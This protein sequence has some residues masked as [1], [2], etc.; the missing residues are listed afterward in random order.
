M[1]GSF[2]RSAIA[3]SLIRMRAAASPPQTVGQELLPEISILLTAEVLLVLSRARDITIIAKKKSQRTD[4]ERD[5]IDLG[6]ARAILL[7]IVIFVPFS[8]ALVLWVVAPFIQPAWI[9]REA[10]DHVF[11]G[12][13]GLAS[14]GFPFT[15]IRRFII[16]VTVNV[17]KEALRL[18]HDASEAEQ[19]AE[20]ET[21]SRE[22]SGDS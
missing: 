1:P 2:R 3:A 8:A 17:M 9:G 6:L 16:R 11:Y 13:L 7:E 19:E 22:V 10:H 18:P 4:P 20:A 12:L 5:K 15:A 21:A 14:Y